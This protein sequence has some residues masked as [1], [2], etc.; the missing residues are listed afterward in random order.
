MGD[1]DSPDVASI[2][3]RINR[4]EGKLKHHHSS[5]WKQRPKINKNKYNRGSAVHKPKSASD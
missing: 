1:K 3:R 4:L 2:I 5:T